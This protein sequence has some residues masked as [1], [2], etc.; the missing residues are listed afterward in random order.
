MLC[1]KS[2]VMTIFHSSYSSS[3]RDNVL[4]IWDIEKKE[5]TSTI[6]VFEVSVSLPGYVISFDIVINTPTYISEE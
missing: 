3:G 5:R 2:R 1:Y 4:M 6:P